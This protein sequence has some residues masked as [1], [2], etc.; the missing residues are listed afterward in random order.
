VVAIVPRRI[1][2]MQQLTIDIRSVA[3]QSHEK[4]VEGKVAFRVVPP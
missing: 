3:S 1:D 2:P 4:R